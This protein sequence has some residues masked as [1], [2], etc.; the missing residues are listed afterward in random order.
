MWH[1]TARKDIFSQKYS[2]FWR[3]R[4]RPVGT[5]TEEIS[6]QT[7]LCQLSRLFYRIKCNSRYAQPEHREHTDIIPRQRRHSALNLDKNARFFATVFPLPLINYEFVFISFLE[8]NIL[9]IIGG[10][11]LD[12]RSDRLCN[13][14]DSQLS[15]IVKFYL[16]RILNVKLM[17]SFLFYILVKKLYLIF[18]IVCNSVAMPFFSNMIGEG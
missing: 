11:S 5:P 10:H 13:G 16:W 18:K 1:I 6:D 17:F 8:L 4:S 2:F 14:R 9:P 12:L 15:S 7:R 3:K